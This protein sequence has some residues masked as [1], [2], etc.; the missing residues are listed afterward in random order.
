MFTSP[1]GRYNRRP[2]VSLIVPGL[3][4][5]EYPTPDDAEWLRRTHGVT[6]VVSL[7]DDAD[8]ASKGL[9][10]EQLANAYQQHGLRFHRLPV[11]DCDIEMLALRLDAIVALLDELL[12]EGGCVYLHCNAGMNRAPTAA[13]AYL[14][15]HHDLSLAAA[16]DF[17]KQRRHCVP[18]MSVLEARYPASGLGRG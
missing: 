9:R 8:I 11:T 14:H 12:T 17:V 4:V 2:D 10:V 3:L 15:R 7:Q 5:G 13:I 16:R 1:S 18:Y 6:A